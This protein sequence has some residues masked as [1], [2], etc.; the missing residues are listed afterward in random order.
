MDKPSTNYSFAVVSSIQ[1]SK[2]VFAKRIV[3]NIN[4]DTNIKFL[5]S[6]GNSVLD[7]AEEKYRLL[8]RSLTTLKNPNIIGIGGTEIS[9]K[10]YMRYYRHFGS[11]Y[12]SFTYNNAYFI[13]LDSTVVSSREIQLSWLMDELKKA[14]DFNKIFIVMDNSPI[15][16]V[17]D[18]TIY[19]KNLMNLLSKYSIS[20]VFYSGDI[21]KL[22]TI[23]N[24]NYYSCGKAGGISQENNYGYVKVDINN[25]I[26]SVN[27]ISVTPQYNNPILRLWIGLWYMIHT[28]LYVHFINI[29]ILL[30]SLLI[31]SLL[32]YNKISKEMNYYRD[33]NNLDDS[34]KNNKLS[35]AMFT[36]NYLPFIG[37]V[38]ISI[39]RLASTL[40]D[41]GNKVVIFAPDYPDNDINDFD[42]IRCKLLKY[43]DSGKFPFAISNIYSSAIEKNFNK[44]RFDIIHVHHPFWMGKKALKLAKKNNIPIVLT[45]HTR[46]EKYSENIPFGKLLFKNILS[47]RIIKMFAQK[48]DG[49]IAPTQ[50]AK[51]YLENI[52][53]SRPKLVMPTGI[54]SKAYENIDTKIVKEIR[55]SFVQ[56]NELLLCSVFRLSPEKN[57]EFLID[58]L[59]LI[60]EKTSVKFKCIIIGE[61]PEKEFLNQKIKTL[62]MDENI[63]LCGKIEPNKIP[64]YYMASD[65]FVFSSQSETQGMVLIEAMEGKCPVV[66]IRSSGTDDVITNNFNGFKTG[67]D[68]TQWSNEVIKLIN[69]KA[70]RD[71]M[72]LN[73]KNY[74]QKYSIDSLTIE[75]EAFYK[76]LIIQKGHDK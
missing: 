38:P 71:E 55:D 3:P 22:D 62:N 29:I 76:M 11:A 69:N 70:L 43:S 75:L 45:Y 7:G 13:F 42:V 15:S 23:E 14:K 33:F 5:I 35:I 49:I 39:Y 19:N 74:A 1:N 48:C 57:A 50:S 56:E 53:V 51:E 68:L 60:K 40:R 17:G 64:A 47:H 63:I 67:P 16:G 2:D 59:K 25:T 44:Y 20:G 58:G 6:T 24:V 54:D 72:S 26:N 36:N 21:Y 30:I 73:A 32:I 46:L 31:F 37:G 27:Y 28:L 4:S 8:N 12:F 65:L 66:C 41:R 61:G 18:N 34:N 10:G 52:G 9:D